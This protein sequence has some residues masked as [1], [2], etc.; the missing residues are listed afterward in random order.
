VDLLQ[1]VACFIPRC[2][3]DLAAVGSCDALRDLPGPGGFDVTGIFDALPQRFG[4]TFTL[5][6]FELERG[7]ENLFSQRQS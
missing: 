3:I 1:L 6:G 7:L 4:K 2:R 5:A